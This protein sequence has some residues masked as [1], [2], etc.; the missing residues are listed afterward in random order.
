MTLKMPFKSS[1]SMPWRLKKNRYNL[2]GAKCNGCGVVHF[3]PRAFC[4]NC[5]KDE[6]MGEHML[7]GS[8]TIESFTKIRVAPDGFESPY[9]IA[10]IR[11]D[12]GP[13]ITAQVVD[14]EIGI[15][16]CVKVVFRKIFEDGRDG[17]IHYGFKFELVE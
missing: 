9:N 17:I 10:L 6:G 11:L 8:G 14:E 4:L 5:G 16:G 12:E 2:I 3:P 15:G 13:L 7:A 1:V